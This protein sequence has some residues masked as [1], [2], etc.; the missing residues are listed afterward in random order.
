[1]DK[2]RIAGAAKDAAGKVESV[3]GKATG[4]ERTEVSGRTREAE[5]TVQ[6]LYGQVKDGVR[7]A[8]EAAASYAK[9]ALDSDTYR[10]G[11]QA[12]TDKV[13]DNP[14]GSLLIAGGIGFALAMLMSR[15]PRRRPNRFNY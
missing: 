13:R 14:L 9:D 3:V 4:D 7:D 11:T 6:N 15:P 5:G 2:D 8:S 1:M 12:L 10:D